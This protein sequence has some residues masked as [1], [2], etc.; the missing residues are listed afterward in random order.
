[1][2]SIGLTNYMKILFSIQEVCQIFYNLQAVWA[3]V[4]KTTLYLVKSCYSLRLVIY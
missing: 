2:D 1:M 4:D 3:D